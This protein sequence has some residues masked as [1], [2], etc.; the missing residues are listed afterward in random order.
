[1]LKH[2]KMRAVLSRK[3]FAHACFFLS[4]SAISAALTADLSFARSVSS[5]GPEAAAR[6]RR[7]EYLLHTRK[8]SWLDKQFF[9]KALKALPEDDL[10][11]CRQPAVM[12]LPG[13]VRCRMRVAYDGAQYTGWERCHKQRQP[14]V[15]RVLDLALSLMTGAD[16]YVRGASRT[17]TGVHARGQAAHFDI[18]KEVAESRPEDWPKKWQAQLNSILP[19]DVR[20]YALEDTTPDWH[21]VGSANGKTYTYKLHIGPDVPIP[22][23][24][25]TRVTLPT[26]M[27][28]ALEGNV[29]ALREVA[30]KFQGTHDFRAF[31]KGDPNRPN[32]TTVRTIRRLDVISEGDGR[33]RIEFDID[34]ALWRMIRCIVWA[35]VG[36]ATG[37]L[38]LEQIDKALADPESVSRP[39]WEIAP[40]EGLCLDVV[41]YSFEDYFT[42]D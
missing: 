19:D 3:R 11:G 4:V 25:C 1:M 26:G 34:G 8:R 37:K 38:A 32:C 28:R 29:R 39:L 14:T 23:E 22:F 7:R 12:D 41:H 15:A 40:P 31:S 10:T 30:E 16:I 6:E 21:A 2:A 20:V 9:E 17:D 35:I 24:R 36:G 13:G 42:P 27:A 5:R 18:P 33:V